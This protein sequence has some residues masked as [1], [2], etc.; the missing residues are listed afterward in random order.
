MDVR[1]H[2]FVPSKSMVTKIFVDKK[3]KAKSRQAMKR[4]VRETY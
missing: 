2:R 1:K 4:L 3:R